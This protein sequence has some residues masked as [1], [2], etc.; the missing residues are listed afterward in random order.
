MKI[1]ENVPIAELTTMRLGGPARFVLEIEDEDEIEKAIEFAKDRNLPVWIMGGGANTIGHDEGFNGVILLNKIPHILLL[2][3]EETHVSLD[4][5]EQMRTLPEDLGEQIILQVGGGVVWDDLV[6]IVSERGYTGVEALSM[7]PGT[8]GA[9]PVQNIGAYGQSV[10][11]VIVSVEAYDLQTNE[12]I[13]IDK[14]EMGLGYRLS[15]FNH[16]ED[17]G[18]Y[19]IPKVTMKLK[20][21][22][23]EQ[24]FYSSLQRYIDKH[25]ETDFSP[26]NIRRMVCEIRRKKLPDPKDAASAGSFFKNVI[27]GPEEATKAEERNIP[28]WRNPDGSG[29]INS[30]WLIE[31]CGLKGKKLHGFRVSDEAALVLINES[32][33]SYADLAAARAEIIKSVKE[34]FGYELEQEPVEITSQEERKI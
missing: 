6:K 27:V 12:I 13:Q 3:D 20:K 29:K 31:T 5:L 2:S 4:V 7:I 9:A 30:G 19:F 1:R 32:A 17:Q 23:L 25:N 21:G 16:G 10:G 28:L 33:K 14:A 8:V 15:R 11:D 34:K 26:K 18:R 22:Q 24:P